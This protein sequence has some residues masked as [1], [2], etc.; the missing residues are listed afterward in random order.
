MIRKSL[1]KRII[2]P[3]SKG[4]LVVKLAGIGLVLKI[5]S[6]IFQFKM[7]HLFRPALSQFFYIV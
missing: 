2:N 5:L 7:E 3:Y 6:T 4:A 1:Y